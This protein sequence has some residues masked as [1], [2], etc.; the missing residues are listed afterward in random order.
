MGN[1]A[2]LS[3]SSDRVR[4]V[5][6]HFPLDQACNRSIERPFTSLPVGPRNSRVRR[7]RWAFWDANDTL[8]ELSNF[9]D[10]QSTKKIAAEL[11]LDP[12]ALDRCMKDEGLADVKN[13]IESDR[14]QAGGTPSFLVDGQVYMGNLPPPCWSRCESRR[15]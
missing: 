1:C 6:R 13:D 8:F 11:K 12:A 15:R 5:H 9:L 4:L 7:P 3:R 14:P 10:T 2:P